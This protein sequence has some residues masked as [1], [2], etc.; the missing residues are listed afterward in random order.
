MGVPADQFTLS[1]VVLLAIL[2]DDSGSIRFSNL[3][4]V[5]RDGCNIVLDAVDES[6]S[7]DNIHAMVQ[8]LN[9]EIISP[10]GSLSSATRLDTSNYNP[11]QGTPLYDGALEFLGAVLSKAQEYSD[12]GIPCRTISLIL[13][14]GED[15]HSSVASGGKGTTPDKCK[16]LITDML[17]SETHII[18]AFGV[19]DASGPSI[20]FRLIFQA[21]GFRDEWIMEAARTK[22]DGSKRTDEEFKGEIRR[23]FQVFSQSAVR[24]SQAAGA[25]FSEQALGGL[26]S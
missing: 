21:M 14:D 25:S 15:V 12:E 26:G 17:R 23:L 3:S 5:V 7:Q 9:G 10:Y 2:V 6:K 8:L 11:N 16:A 1:E 18:A 4:Q 20:D 13:T 24:A 19:E 22:S